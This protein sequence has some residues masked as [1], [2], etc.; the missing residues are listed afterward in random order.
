MT[1]VNAL[2][3]YSHYFGW[4]VVIAEVLTILIFQRIKI[5]HVLIMFAIEV[6]VFVPW[7]LA[8]WKAVGSGASVIQ[9]IGWIG[10]PGTSAV[11]TFIFDLVEPFYFQQSSI[12]PSSLLYIS[13]PLLLVVAAA[14]IWNLSEWKRHERKNVLYLLAMFALVPIVLAFVLSWLMPVSIWGS[15]HLIIVFAPVSIAAAVYVTSVSLEPVRYALVGVTLIVIIA[16]FVI[17]AGE[18]QPQFIWCKWEET[19]AD[20]AGDGA[21]IYAFEDLAVYHLW[22]ATRK[23]KVRV[24]KVNGVPDMTEDAAYFIPRGFD[25]IAITNTDELAVDRFFFAFRDTEWNER[26]PP[27]NFFVKKGY[28]IGKIAASEDA[29]GMRAFMGEASK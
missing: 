12:Q 11:L 29:Q 10:R 20:V 16:G 18:E 22:F 7:I 25:G 4:F 13:V 6:A 23:D 24:V 8:L 5:R 2:M 17:R 14:K 1:I 3:I 27:I 15:R 9:N 19:V 26:H 21:V 28:K